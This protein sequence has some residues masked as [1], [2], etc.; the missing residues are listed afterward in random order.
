M[1]RNHHSCNRET[2]SLTASALLIAFVCYALPWHAWA[3]F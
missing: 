1:P 2:W 3:R